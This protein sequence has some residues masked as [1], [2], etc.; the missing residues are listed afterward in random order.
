[1]SDGHLYLCAVKKKVLIS[2]HF[3]SNNCKAYQSLLT[4]NFDARY[5]NSIVRAACYDSFNFVS[6]LRTFLLKGGRG[7]LYVIFQRKPFDLLSKTAVSRYYLG[8]FA[9]LRKGTRRFVM[10][11][12]RSA[13]SSPRNNSAPIRRISIKFHISIFLE[14]LCRKFK[15]R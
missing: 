14:N 10:C 6:I 2:L 1:M 12:C 5:K 4:R 13:R 3:I 15:F 7:F 9:K 11:V 8:S